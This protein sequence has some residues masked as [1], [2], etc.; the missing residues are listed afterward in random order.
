[1]PRGED[2]RQRLAGKSPVEIAREFEA[3]LVTEMIGAM[4]RTIPDS[5]LLAG[6][7]AHRVLDGAFDHEVARSLTARAGLG[8]AEQIAKQISR[9]TGQTHGEAQRAAS[10]IASVQSHEATRA[11]APSAGE[12]IA[13]PVDGRVTSAFGPRQDP[14]NGEPE[15]HGGIDIAA[16]SGTEVHAVADGTVVFAGARGRAGNV[17]EVRHDDDLVTT[18]GH[19]DRTLV[20]AGQRIA[21]GEALATVGSTGRATGPHLHFVVKQ[22]GQVVDPERILGAEPAASPGRGVKAGLG[23]A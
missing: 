7:S 13:R 4:R 17:V 16:P 22:K 5:G 18:Y 15:F 6:S 2:T 1:M 11:V 9:Q 10:T 12:P 21:P 8:I 23:E 3:I 14:V 20:K 19:L